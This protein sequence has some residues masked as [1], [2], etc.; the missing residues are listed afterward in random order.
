[1]TATTLL[2]LAGVA[3]IIP[4]AANVVAPTQLRWD[5]ELARLPKLR[6]QMCNVY[7]H[8]TGGTIV[9]LGLVSLFCAPDLAA[10][11]ALAR[12]VCAYTAIFWAVRLWLKRDNDFRPHLSTVWLRLSYHALTALFIV[13]VAIDGWGSLHGLV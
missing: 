5:E 12:A 9:A 1:M 7:C 13:F 10:G 2:Q 3:H 6:R 4:F 8:Q 11:T